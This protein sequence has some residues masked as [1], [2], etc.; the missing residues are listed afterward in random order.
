MGMLV[1]YLKIVKISVFLSTPEI[2]AV[3]FREV[4]V[5]NVWII[6]VLFAEIFAA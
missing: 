1:P 4:D 2:M 3:Y 5:T 6:E